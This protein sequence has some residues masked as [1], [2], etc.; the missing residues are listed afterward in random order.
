MTDTRKS[1]PLDD[2]NERKI[3]ADNRAFRLFVQEVE[4]FGFEVRPYKGRNFYDGPA[5]TCERH[6]VQDLIRATS[7]SILTD[8]MGMGKILYPG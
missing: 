1:N 5:V 7:M 6:E 4:D 3:W 2:E 8:D